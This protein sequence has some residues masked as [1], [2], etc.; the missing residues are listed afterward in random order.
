MP[1]VAS[2]SP[3]WPGLKFPKGSTEIKP[4]WRHN[5]KQCLSL[6]FG[7]C[8]GGL[9]RLTLAPG[10]GRFSRWSFGSRRPR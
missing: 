10:S 4:T 3:R 5:P 6:P 2:I 8:F 7:K 1:C 9:G